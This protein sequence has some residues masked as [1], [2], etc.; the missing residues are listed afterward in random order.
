MIGFTDAY[1]GG[2]LAYWPDTVQIKNLDIGYTGLNVFYAFAMDTSYAAFARGQSS[3]TNVPA[4]SNI[5]GG[6]GYFSG[7]AVDSLSIYVQSPTA[8]T[9][10][11]SVLLDAYCQDRLTKMV[12]SLQK[13]H[14]TDTA[15]Y[16]SDWI[17]TRPNRCVDFVPHL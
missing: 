13:V 1:P 17:S 2:T 7:A 15:A 12:D 4:Y 11:V 9:F 5:Q 3:T 6:Y 8:D 16:V 14:V 10:A